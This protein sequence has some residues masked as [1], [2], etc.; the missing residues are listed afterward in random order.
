MRV[1]FYQYDILRG[2][3]AANLDKVFKALSGQKFDLIVLPE[4]FTTGY[5]FDSREQALGLAEAVPDG[6][7]IRA[8][9]DFARERDCFVVGTIPELEGDVLFNAA[10]LIG[11]GGFV[12]K[13]R[14]IHLSKLEQRHF[15][16][17]KTFAVFEAR[18]WKIGIVTCFDSWF[19]ELSRLLSL[20]G[21]QILCNPA[22][23][24]GDMTPCVMRTRSI[25][26]RAFSIT[27]NRLGEEKSGHTT[28]I[29]R[30]ESQIVDPDGAVIAK[31]GGTENLAAVEINPERASKKNTH[32]CDFS[33]EWKRYSTT[34]ESS[35]TAE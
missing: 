28:A 20:R 11:P 26:N 24:G 1:G 25:E 4:F 6:E 19:P 29:F 30:G 23:F 10:F 21:A 7:T 35:L 8:V 32:L 12:G 13:Q 34:L 22:N 9:S 3:K 17:G 31:A 2:D 15:T 33:K 16:R 18:E 27:A 14:K 5:L